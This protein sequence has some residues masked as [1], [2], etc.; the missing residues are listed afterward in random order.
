MAGKDYYYILGV[1]RNASADEIKKAYRKTALKHHP[2]RNPGNPGSEQKF[3]DAAVAYA[4]LSDSNK[5]R[6]YDTYGEEGLRGYHHGFTSFEDVFSAFS[7]IFGDLFGT[8]RAR[9]GPVRGQSLHCELDIELEDVIEG[10][11]RTVN[12]DRPEICP[13]CSGVGG[14]KQES[15][16]TCGGHGQVVHRQGFFQVQVVCPACGGTGRIIKKPCSQCRG[17]GRVR[18]RREIRVRIPQGIE[19]G[20]RLKIAGEGE[21][22][23]N[24]GPPG[25]LFVQVRLKEHIYFERIGEH[26]ACELPITMAQATLG[27]EIE[28]PTLDGP[29]KL[30][31]PRGTQTGDVLK[32]KGKGLPPLHGM[33]RGDELVRIYVEVPR[34]L[35]AEQESLIRE[36]AQTE[37]AK[38]TPRKRGILFR[39]K[40]LFD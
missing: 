16:S 33:K 6:R 31:V 14:S 18:V 7:D 22:G 32:L 37:D 5:R 24:G 13:R 36:Y 35:T 19:D 25:D 8:R 17:S 34:K 26:V 20:T 38:V 2:D 21:P 4:V 27:A 40:N 15:C 29:A 10:V 3:K 9:R 11:E 28:V 39:F 30:A 1:S 12:F 23:P